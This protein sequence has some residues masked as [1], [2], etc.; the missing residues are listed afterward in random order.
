MLSTLS[1]AGLSLD[2]SAPFLPF[3]LSLEGGAKLMSVLSEMYDASKFERQ[4]KKSQFAMGLAL[5]P[6]MNFLISL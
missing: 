2:K 3:F 4:F 5:V 1:L 6:T